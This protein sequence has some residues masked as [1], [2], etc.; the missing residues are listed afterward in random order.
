[1][2]D[3]PRT[4]KPAL[5]VLWFAGLSI[6]QSVD[7]VHQG[8]VTP[9]SAYISPSRYTNAFFRF[10]LPLPQDPSLYEWGQPADHYSMFG[11]EVLF[12]LRA[13]RRDFEFAFLVGGDQSGATSPDD[14]R[15][16]ASG[17]QCLRPKRVKI[18]G[19]EFWRGEVEEK[20]E[21]GKI[22]IVR[23]ATC[24]DDHVLVFYLSGNDAHLRSVFQRAIESVTFFDPA[25][26][27]EAAGPGSHPY[28]VPV[29]TS[30][31]IGRLDLGGVE[32]H[33]YRNDALGFQFQFPADW[34]VA[35]R[36]TLERRME[37]GHQAVW[38]DDPAAA[39]DHEL[40]HNC[41]RTLL[42][43]TQDREISKPRNPL[44]HLSVADGACFPEVRF[45]A[46]ARDRAGL[47]AVRKVLAGVP[48][49][50]ST[51]RVFRMEG[52]L[53]WIIHEG[54]KEPSHT[55]RRSGTTGPQP[56]TR[57]TRIK[58]MGKRSAQA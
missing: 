5:M 4:I 57:A 18:G 15:R 48:G 14:V 47:A 36:E 26:L 7:A 24:I 9:A 51:L 29:P 34:F 49:P 38:G 39:R 53:T 46:S 43:V 22:H 3:F 1:M 42:W 28:P 21:D 31:R 30:G 52:R 33:T 2:N 40:L 20:S 50:K 37:A 12:G 8:P 54:A 41:F 11:L 17:T 32:G 58:P 55:G 35:D 10:S 27:K 16:V 13:A 25:K 19:T 6:A 44:I 56:A 45:P 23:Y